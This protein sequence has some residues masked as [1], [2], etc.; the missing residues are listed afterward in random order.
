MNSIKNFI[1]DHLVNTDI[2]EM[3]QSLDQY[4]KDIENNIFIILAH[5]LLILKPNEE[6]NPEFIDHWKKELS[7]F[8]NNLCDKKLKT[9]DN[10]K[11]RYK[12]IYDVLYNK[13]DFDDNDKLIY[14]IYNILYQE[15]Y[16]LDDK[17]IYDDFINLF[18]IFQDKYLDKLIEVIALQ[19]FSQIKMFVNDLK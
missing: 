18:H 17:N 1:A 5:I 9:K 12:H 11:T 7:G 2:F 15:G 8:I 16:D 13:Y 3:A 10:Y 14:K 4:K 6:G 19:D